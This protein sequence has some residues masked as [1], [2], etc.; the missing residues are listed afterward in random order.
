MATA[1][2]T[3]TMLS[4]LFDALLQTNDTFTTVRNRVRVMKRALDQH[5]EDPFAHECSLSQMPR[6]VIPAPTPA[7]TNRI[8]PEGI[9]TM[10][11]TA[12]FEIHGGGQ[13]LATSERAPR[14]IMHV[15]PT[16]VRLEIPLTTYIP[17]K[18]MR[19]G[20]KLRIAILKGT[21]HNA[22][23]GKFDEVAWQRLVL[24][25]TKKTPHPSTL[26]TNYWTCEEQGLIRPVKSTGSNMIAATPLN[27]LTLE[28]PGPDADSQYEQLTC[29]PMSCVFE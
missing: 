11:A 14:I 18:R 25:L 16:T 26:V 19:T 10:W 15:S 1:D 23:T 17:E 7:P 2:T 9:I 3:H 13:R 5:V 4:A 12:H 28:L 20:S 24:V 22:E 27:S 21:T 6:P 29:M 8:Q